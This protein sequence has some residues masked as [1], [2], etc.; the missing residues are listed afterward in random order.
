[1]SNAGRLHEPC[2]IKGC[3][4][5]LEWRDGMSLVCSANGRHRIVD[6]DAP[7]PIARERQPGTAG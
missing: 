4:G 7:R 3:T 2:P 1:M 5:T 6:K